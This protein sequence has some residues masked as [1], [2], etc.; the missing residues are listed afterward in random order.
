MDLR[1]AIRTSDL[2]DPAAPSLARPVGSAS[3]GEEE[4]GEECRSVGGKQ[5]NNVLIGCTG[6][7][8]STHLQDLLHEL[9]KLKCPVNMSNILWFFTAMRN[10]LSEA[11]K[12]ICFQ[13]VKFHL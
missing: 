13:I 6:D 5:K 10:L 3:S 12:Q 2:T 7:I 1:G 4:D 9:A 8:S 11:L